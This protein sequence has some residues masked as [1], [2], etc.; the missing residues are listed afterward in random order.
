MRAGPVGHLHAAAV[1]GRHGREA[2]PLDERM[3]HIGHEIVHHLDVA[4]ETAA[5]DD[6]RL[7]GELDV[8]ALVGSHQ[9]GDFA[10]LHDHVL[11]LGREKELGARGLGRLAVV[12]MDLRLVAI[13]VEAADGRPEFDGAQ[14]IELMLGLREERRGHR[15]EIIIAQA[16][17]IPIGIRAGILAELH[18]E[19]LVGIVPGDGH[20]VLIELDRIDMGHAAL[21]KDAG[22]QR[23][24]FV[25]DRSIALLGLLLHKVDLLAFLGEFPAGGDACEAVAADDDVAIDLLREV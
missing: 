15:R 1:V 2:F 6:D 25:A 21:L 20:I 11:R 22:V 8:A 9:S 3:V 18:H 16:F 13:A 5:C 23:G 19:L 17:E 12:A 4:A 7:A 14:M 24:E 10:V